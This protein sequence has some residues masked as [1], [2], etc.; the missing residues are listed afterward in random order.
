MN[1]FPESRSS[2]STSVDD[3]NDVLL[4]RIHAQLGDQRTSSADAQRLRDIATDVINGMGEVACSLA[5][6][7]LLAGSVS[8]QPASIL[9]ADD[10]RQGVPSCL[11]QPDKN[12]SAPRCF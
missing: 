8:A 3:N 2:D 7:L 5:V 12:G 10:A 9:S 4:K 11:N 6:V 1:S